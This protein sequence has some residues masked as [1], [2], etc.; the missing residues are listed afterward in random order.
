MFPFVRCGEIPTLSSSSAGSAGVGGEI[1]SVVLES[2]SF[3]AG[4]ALWVTVLELLGAW[5]SGITESEANCVSF[6]LAVGWVFADSDTGELSSTF[7]AFGSD[8]VGRLCVASVGLFL[9]SGVGY[10]TENKNVT[11][12]RGK[13][14]VY[15]PHRPCLLRNFLLN[16]Q[17]AALRFKKKM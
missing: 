14:P 9:L 8:D 15:L 13:D 1:C 7:M 10:G 12:K 2:S 6:A 3:D 4:G 16:Q 5:A 11:G 17:T